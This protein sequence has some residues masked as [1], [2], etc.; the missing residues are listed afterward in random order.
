M[1]V[2]APILSK[3]YAVK[4]YIDSKPPALGNLTE[5][6]GLIVNILSHFYRT[7]SLFGPVVVWFSITRSMSAMSTSVMSPMTVFFTDA[8]ASP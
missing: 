7:I 4:S 1:N 8:M 6:R 2:K 5:R 3:I